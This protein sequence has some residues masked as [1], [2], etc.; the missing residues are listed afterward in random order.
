MLFNFKLYWSPVTYVN[1]ALV[2]QMKLET[3]L[4]VR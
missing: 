1:L 3:N 4:Y 2:G